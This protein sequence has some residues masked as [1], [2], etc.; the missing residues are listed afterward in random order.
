MNYERLTAK[1]RAEHDK[2]ILRI[3]SASEM[4]AIFNDNIQRYV[5]RIIALGE[6]IDNKKPEDG[7]EQKALDLDTV[8]QQ[9]LD[10]HRLK[11]K[12]QIK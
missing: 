10:N 3:K 2:L 4:V 5:K 12:G 11:T 9:A 1:E 7:E 8:L 6:P